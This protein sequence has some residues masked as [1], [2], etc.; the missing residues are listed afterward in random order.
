MPFAYSP[1]ASARRPDLTLR[2]AGRRKRPRRG[3]RGPA[4]IGGTAQCASGTE[5]KGAA[6]SGW[7]G[8]G[9]RRLP[10]AVTGTR[11]PPRRWAQDCLPAPAGGRPRPPRARPASCPPPA[12]P[13]QAR[14]GLALTR[15]LL[16]APGFG[17]ALGRLSAGAP[18]SRAFPSHLCPG[19]TRRARDAL[20]RRWT[21]PASWLRPEAGRERPRPLA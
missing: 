14:L 18:A 1:S 20:R 4:R 8:A 19:K 9:A 17:F 6:T 3:A 16:L 13:R 5:G 21:R 11:S 2:A 15:L 7:P 10:P 12:S